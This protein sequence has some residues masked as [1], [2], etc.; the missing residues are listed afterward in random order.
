M[1]D[2]FTYGFKNSPIITTIMSIVLLLTIILILAGLLY[3]IDSW[4]LPNKQGEGIVLNK[5]FTP[6]HTTM[7]L[8]YNAATKTSMPTPIYHSDS[9]EIEVGMNK[10]TDT[11]EINE[12]QFNKI[13]VGDIAKINYSIGRFSSGMYIKKCL[14]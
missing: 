4:F 9:W 6:A 10:L 3:A 7:I 14:N 5:K 1:I 12:E 2:M 13:A 11:V 8:T